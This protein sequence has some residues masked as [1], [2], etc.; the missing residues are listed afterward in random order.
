[1]KRCIALVWLLLLLLF[2]GCLRGVPLDKYCYVLDLGVERG[3]NMPY[4]F[5]FLLNEDTAGDGE[6]GGDKGQVSMVS[7]EERSLF[8]AID[9]LAGALPAQ[10]SFERTTLLAFSRE[11]SEAGE[12]K[13]I[14]EGALSR[15]KI[16]QNVRVIVVEEDMRG[17]FQGLIS[18]GDPSMNR[19]KANVK[20][21]EEN[22]GY[23]EDWGLSRMQ[24]AFANQTGDALLPYAGL[25]GGLLRPDMAGGEAYP[26][27]GGGLLGE[28]QI[29]TS[30][31]GSAVFAGDRM[32]GVLSGQHTMLVLMAKGVFRAGHLRLPWGEG[33]VD[34]ALYAVGRPKRSWVDG[35]FT[36]EIA[37]EADLESPAQVDADSEALIAAA[38]SYLAEEMDRVFAV[39][40]AAGAD[41]FEVGKE[42][43][44][45]FRTWDDW[46]SCGFPARLKEAR[47]VFSVK[48]KL[49][50]SPRD[51]ALE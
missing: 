26:Y 1:M 37:L 31:S 40:A 42:A 33:A 44:R 47:A 51:P 32:V 11:L 3:E 22:Y 46:Q 29:R 49:S 36:C 25:V 13:A 34:L 27:L 12:I 20:L 14:T 6:G 23:V 48:V 15:L 17:V 39:T 5:V 7:A 24:E 18:Q 30:L 41:V 2:A 50:H 16:R 35:V 10:L 19:L 9:A 8:A 4:R 38:E 21:F 43:I 28:G 45:A